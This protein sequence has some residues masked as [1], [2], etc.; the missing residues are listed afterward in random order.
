VSCMRVSSETDRRATDLQRDA[1]LDA[2]VGPQQ[3][4]ADSANGTRDD[5]PGLQLALA[6]PSATP[7]PCA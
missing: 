1:W 4:W 3:L 6:S 5:R 7:S 2:G